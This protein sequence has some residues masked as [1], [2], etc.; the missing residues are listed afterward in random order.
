LLA[1][2]AGLSGELATL[3]Q[4]LRGDGLDI[5]T[6]MPTDPLYWML[7]TLGL[8]LSQFFIVALYLRLDAIASG[9]AQNGR[10]DAAL[11]RLPLFIVLN[12]VYVVAVIVGTLLLVVPGLILIVSLAVSSPVYLLEMKGPLGSLKES[13]ELVWNDWWRTAAIVTVGGVVAVVVYVVCGAI[14]GAIGVAAAG[15]AVFVALITVFVALTLS[16]VLVLPFMLSMLL[17]VYWDLK[18]RRHGE[19]L[20]A[21]VRAF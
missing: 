12:L 10:V 8:V 2:L 9:H 20:T 16:S 7:Y 15:D 17:N 6:L 11:A 21:R 13:H 18:L 1:L 14:A 4:V 5:G 19:D 3:Y